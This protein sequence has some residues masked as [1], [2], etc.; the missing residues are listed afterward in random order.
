MFFNTYNINNVE[1]LFTLCHF[2]QSK[3]YTLKSQDKQFY[4][5]E[6]TANHLDT[7][8]IVCVCVCK[9]VLSKERLMKFVFGYLF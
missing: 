2:Q 7:M 6:T 3:T 9:G 4:T 1:K 5:S 8:S